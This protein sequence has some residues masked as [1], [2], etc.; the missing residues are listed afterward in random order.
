MHFRNTDVPAAREGQVPAHWVTKKMEEETAGKSLSLPL[1]ASGA[2]PQPGHSGQEAGGP[3]ISKRL[4]HRS[5]KAG[6]RLWALPPLLP[7]FI[8]WPGLV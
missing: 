3:C 6:A 5:R 2:T 8:L 7:E 1:R 4:P